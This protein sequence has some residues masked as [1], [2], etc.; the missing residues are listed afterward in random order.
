M[1]E[2]FIN[3]NFV[4][5]YALVDTNSSIKYI[6]VTR[7]NPKQRLNNHIY[8]AK[9]FPLKNKR[10]EWI[11]SSNFQINQIILDVVPEEETMFWEQFWISLCKTWGFELV[12]SNNGGGGSLKKSESFSEWLSNRNIGNTYRKNKKHSTESKKLMSDK[13]KGRTSPN[14]GKE[15]SEDHRNKISESTKGRISPR[16]GIKVLESTL[17]KKR[18]KI[19]QLTLDDTIIKI[20]DSLSDASETLKITIGNISS[21]C[22]GNRKT[23]GGYKWKYYN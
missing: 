2:K 14:K 17:E 4:T 13:A 3:I 1:A 7:R 6:G 10:T 16:K 20:W 18:V 23:C 22:K 12:N 5:I 9:Q 15:L 8:E 19:V 11:S 21:T